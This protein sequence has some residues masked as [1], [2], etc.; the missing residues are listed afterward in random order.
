MQKLE[1]KV[2]LVE[3][4]YEKIKQKICDFELYPGQEISDFT[5]SKELGMSRTPIRQALG[6]LENDGLIF[7]GGQGRGYI[8]CEITEEE[9]RDIFAA[10]EC[11]ETMS[12]KLAM[13]QG[14]KEESFAYLEKINRQMEEMDQKGNIKR[15]F[16]FDQ[17]FHNYLVLLSGN[18]R[19]IRFYETLRIQLSRLR[20]LSYLE[21][22]YQKKAYNDHSRVIECIRE[23]DGE[24]AV[25]ALTVHIETSQDDYCDLL[26]NR[27][28]L[29][30]YGMLRFLMKTT[31][32]DEEIG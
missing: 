22:S 4:A 10:R 18:K 11:I 14:I 17:Q 15:Q 12:L 9:I 21:R 7:D 19:L 8:V 3:E 27:I 20:V 32:G 25:R 6:Q 2:S 23:K 30:S 16:Y 26:T 1:N 24:G 13:E 29:D 5:L 28:A 31:E